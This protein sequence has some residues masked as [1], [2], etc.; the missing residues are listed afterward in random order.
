MTRRLAAAAVGLVF[1][2][3]VI[4]G[5]PFL[6]TVENYERDR[7]RLDL[8]S[9]A[10]VIGATVEDELS[11]KDASSEAR[12]NQITQ[13]VALA[14]W[15]RTGARVVIIDKAGL[16]RAD[17]ASSTIDSAA[18]TTSTDQRSM[19][20]RPEFRA[21][22]SGQFATV[23]RKSNDLG[24]S[25]LFVAVPVSSAGKLLGA[26][27]VSFPT[28]DVNRRMAV[29]RTR[30]IAL[31]LAMTALVSVLAIWLARLVVRPVA[32]LQETTRLFGLGQLETR[33][34]A[35]DGPADIRRLASEFN[36][37]AERIDDIVNTQH[38]FVA[39]AS[40]EL[41]SPLT[42]IRLQLE[43]MEYASGDALDQ[44]RMRA[45]EEVTRLSRNVDG[46]L[47]LARQDAPTRLVSAT[48]LT[49]IVTA[50]AAFWESLVDERQV[51]MRTNI[52]S[53]LTA[54]ADR[55]RV[56]TVLDNLISNAIDAA[57]ADSTIVVSAR[58]TSTQVE[59]HII[60]EGPGM[61][62]EQRVAAFD[63]F[64]RAS[65]H[66]P[67]SLGGSGLGLAIA[68]KLVAADLGTIRLDAAG[69]HGIDAVVCYRKATP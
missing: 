22:L 21:A 55:D 17:T 13:A 51:H 6:R 34:R 4:F 56:V 12:P 18:A 63:R 53:R 3:L 1:T 19:R 66:R 7:L 29:Q 45:L 14:Y 26:V 44:R 49:P 67:T 62:P 68:R 10:V 23:T 37:M 32:A 58:L 52:P 47:L 57:P 35:Q 25:S 20:S 24:Y 61:S 50:R 31:G 2:M 28:S 15:K 54:F 16:V 48:D 69:H 38:A 5:V 33:A 43:A 30:L 41:R 42:A 27:R 8:V 46:L 64:W 59:L 60:D 65:G 39:D 36:T 9:D 11:D 40:H